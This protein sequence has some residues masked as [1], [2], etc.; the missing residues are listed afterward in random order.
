[1]A[2]RLVVSC[3]IFAV[4]F[5]LSPLLRHSAFAAAVETPKGKKIPGRIVDEGEDEYKMETE[6]PG[7][8]KIIFNVDKDKV[9]PYGTVPGAGRIEEI[10]GTAEI[11]RVGRTYYS[12]VRKGMP[13][14]PGDEIRT[15]PQSKVVITLETTAVNGVGANSEF[16]LENLEKNPDTKF[17]DIKVSLPK[18]DL[19]SE[20]GRLKTKGSSFEVAT[21]TAVTGVRGTVFHIEVAEKT[22][23]T[24]V[25]VLS[26]QVGVISSALPSKEIVLG[27]KEALFVQRGKE[28]IRFDPT[29]LAERIGKLIKEWTVESKFF[30]E[31]TALAGIGQ[32]EEIEIEPTLPESEKQ[33]I[34]DAIQAGWEK[35]SED[36]F[37]L[38]KALKMFYLDFGRFP[39][40]QE[41][42]LN[43]L[44]T[45]TGTPQWNGP[46]TEEKYLVDHYG[47]PYGYKVLRDMKGNRYAEITTFGYD[48]QP[49]TSDDRRK[50]VLEEDALR[51]QDRKDYR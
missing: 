14:N 12:T 48:K 6:L 31:A 29:T 25:S 15:G 44:V 37:E 49:G 34:Y 23:E 4:V 46:Y 39:T 42:G 9:D 35:A 51:W 36:Y 11:K 32:I 19:W 1:M 18:G 13:V 33:K 30:K 41:G 21:P 3:L 20:V 26:G 5:L 45:S 28:P 38:D 16:V 24:N 7:G 2:K 10:H 8:G 50:M 27:K 47:V 17:V 40:V 43:A 22:A